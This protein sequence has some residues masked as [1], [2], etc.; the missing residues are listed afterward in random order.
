MTKKSPSILKQLKYSFLGFGLLM[1][2][3]FPFYANFFVEWKPGML[4]WFITGCIVAGITIGISNHML[5]EW[6]LIGKLRKVA[7]AAERI[8]SGDL[9]E[10]CG[11]RSADTVGEITGG[12]DAMASGLRD[13]LSGMTASANTVEA[14]A[15]E[16]GDSMHSLGSSLQEYRQNEQEIIKVINGMADASRSILELSDSAGNSAV[17]ADQLVRNG[18]SQVA[19]TEQAIS[20]L[21]GA[22]RKISANAASLEKSA[23]EVE[24]AVSAIREISEQTNL[25]ALNAAIEAARAGEQGRGFAVVADEVR[26][27]S[28]Q[29]AQATKRI[30]AV[31]KQVSADVSSTVSISE[32]NASAVHD[33]LQASRLSS[34]TF[35]QIEQATSAMKTS[36]EAVREAA[37]DQQMLVGLVLKRI[38]ENQSSSEATVKLTSVC[39]RESERMVT[40]A[41]DLN[42]AT[43]RF[44]V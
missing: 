42:E 29:A 18:V 9:R 20:V 43:R 23:K 44:I 12:F 16:I 4:G 10:G 17:S 1:G 2:L 32:E 14:T 34:E 8:Q 22:S 38:E 24:T 30:D 27:L 7:V 28:E 6:L 41:H 11:I 15:R 13:T 37:D 26:K 39:V 3:I 21:D 19:K 5:L 33:G 31:L 40:T 25:L 36:V 35:V